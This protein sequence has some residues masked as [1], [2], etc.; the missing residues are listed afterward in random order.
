MPLDGSTLDMLGEHPLPAGTLD[1][2]RQAGLNPSK[3]GCCASP[4]R[5]VRGCPWAAPTEISPEG[6]CIFGQPRYG[7]FRGKK[8]SNVGIYLRTSGTDGNRQQQLQMP[9][10]AFIRTLKSRMLDGLTQR[11]RGLDGE[12]IRIIAQEGEKIRPR[13][14]VSSNPS[15]PNDPLATFVMKRAPDGG[16]YEE[17]VARLP[18]PGEMDMANYDHMAWSEELARQKLE[19]AMFIPPGATAEPDTS[20]F[21]ETEEFFKE[22]PG[23]GPKP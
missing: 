18:L 14:F 22:E 21:D 19:E 1:Q 13:I 20:Q 8:V 16:I 11:A 2:I 4:A 7:G 10:H 5:G 15:N 23:A 17:E 12:I 3:V 6:E 9:C